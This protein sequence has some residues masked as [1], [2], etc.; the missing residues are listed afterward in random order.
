LAILS[1]TALSELNTTA[2]LPQYD[3]SAVRVGI[4]HFGVGNFHRV[5]EAVYVD[6]CLHLPHQVEWG[7]VGI[8]L[9]DSEAA[10]SKAENFNRQDGLYSVT[11]FAPDGTSQSRII[12]AMKRYL[13]A[14]SDPGAVLNQLAHPDL[15][16]VSLTITEGG[17]LID[18]SSGRFLLEHPD[19]QYDLVNELPRNVFGYIVHAL[20]RRRNN[21]VAPFTV[22]SCDNLRHN[23]DTARKAVLAVADALDPELAAWI[24]ERGAFPNSMVDRIAPYVTPAD[25]VRLNAIT[26]IDDAVPAMSES[27]L[28]WV[29]EDRFSAGRPDLGSVG[30]E[31]RDDIE[32]FETVKGRLL[33]ASHVL[34]SYP[35]LLL[36]HRFVHDAL[37]DHRVRRL[38]DAFMVRDSIPL[39]RPP[40]GVS[41]TAYKDTIIERF[42]NPAVGDQLIR[43]A[44]DGSVKIPVF[45]SATIGE[46]IERGADIR[47]EAFLLACYQKYLGA[48]DDTGGRI[49]VSEP[50]LSEDDRQE[51]D[52]PDGFGLFR[53][54]A[55]AGLKLTDHATF[56]ATFK[57]FGELLDSQGVGKTIDEVLTESYVEEVL[58]E[59]K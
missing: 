2:L 5:H 15:R 13:H 24:D 41:L 7:I 22:V 10:K 56:A 11:E 54:S 40:D 49:D 52:A 35:S 51:I 48:V 30:V 19:I 26:A 55:F 46:L 17:Y 58:G 36:G 42:A 3:R 31:L 39:L 23:G 18:E 33:N 29:I 37:A 16:I 34:L 53:I 28:Q 50:S 4:A 59:S 25:R 32:L 8:G 47:R 57:R 6:R 1:N 9:S 14:P 12:G 27:Y 38:I 20:A 44:T 43:I 21:G 45:H